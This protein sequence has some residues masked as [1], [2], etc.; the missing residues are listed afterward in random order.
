VNR[1]VHLRRV[2]RRDL[3]EI[4]DWFADRSLAT[5][6]RFSTAA[7][8]ALSRLAGSPWIGHPHM[9]EDPFLRPIRTWPVPGFEAVRVYYL[10][11][12]AKI[13]V[14]RIIHG[15]RDVPAILEE[16]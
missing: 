6:L 10:A 7:G 13:D 5:A 14:I 9:P 8:V 4:A 2:A 3:Q 12:E 16:E 15:A 1:R 11:T